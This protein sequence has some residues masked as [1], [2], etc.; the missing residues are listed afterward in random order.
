MKQGD[1]FWGNRKDTAHEGQFRLCISQ[2]YGIGQV[3][4]D[5]NTS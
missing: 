5:T 1:L 3:E 4:I 2:T